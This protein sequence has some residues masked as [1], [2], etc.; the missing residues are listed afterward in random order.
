MYAVFQS[1]KVGTKNHDTSAQS[2]YVYLVRCP[3]GL[4]CGYTTDPVRRMKQHK[5]KG[6]ARS[7]KMLGGAQEMRVVAT[8]DSKRAA[9][10]H[11]YELKRTMSKQEK[12]ELWEKSI[13][14]LVE[15]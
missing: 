6:G 2:A 9:M 10:S 3:R 15:I 1:P 12:E 8:F 14:G 11:E 7:I 13:S 5:G 4:Y